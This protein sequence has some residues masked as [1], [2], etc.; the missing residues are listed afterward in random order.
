[1]AVIQDRLA[2]LYKYNIYRIYDIKHIENP[3]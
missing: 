2:I 3:V 1:M